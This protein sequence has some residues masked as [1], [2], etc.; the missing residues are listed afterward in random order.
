MTLLNNG[1]Y[2]ICLSILFI[3]TI[4][5]LNQRFVQLPTTIA[6]MASSLIF[7]LIVILAG[8]SGHASFENL[9]I[10]AVGRMDFSSV[11]LQGMLSFMLFAGAMNINIYQLNQFKL[12]ISVLAIIGT[13]C[14]TL[15]I[16]ILSYY[17]LLW[18]GYSINFLYCLIFGA[19]ISPTDPIAVLA[20]FKNIQGNE[21]IDITLTG[22]SLFNDGVGIALFMT[23]LVLV[24]DPSQAHLVTTF[25]S[26]F[27]REF[28]GGIAFGCLLGAIGLY[29]LKPLTSL[30]TSL[31]LTLTIASVGYAIALIF[32]ISGPLAMVAA[33]IIIGSETQKNDKLLHNFWELL[34]DLL[35]SALFFLIGIE[36]IQI[37]NFIWDWKLAFWTI[38][39]V[40]LARAVTVA[41]PLSILKGNK[42]Y[43]AKYR[44][45]L[46][47]GGLRGGL[48]IALALT[49]PDS[50][51]KDIVLNMTYCVVIFSI[52]IQG[53]TVPKLL[54]TQS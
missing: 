34:D 50:A 47:W 16:G 36:L 10:S 41:V 14:S 28:V 20:L 8:K 40:L 3:T 18:L 6:I 38:I 29:L 43:P 19:L 17:L 42:Q 33:G 25:C 1:Y 39:I 26:L 35:N 2:L 31:L 23:L 44:S 5:Y 37:K 53:L 30:K 22:E 32:D 24:N 15:I 12:E 11:L 52:L 13:I 27:F 46:I 49:L 7:S 54:P 48:A 51:V 21:Q 4:T 45:I 9:I